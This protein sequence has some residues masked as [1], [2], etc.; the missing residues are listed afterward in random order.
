MAGVLS[1]AVALVLA[2]C[3]PLRVL[4]DEQLR[5]TTERVVSAINDAAGSPP[6]VVIVQSPGVGVM[7]VKHGCGIIHGDEILVGE[8]GC[9]GSLND[10]AAIVLVHEIG[11]ALGRGHSP[12][13]LSVMFRKFRYMP[14][15]EAAASL[16]LEFGR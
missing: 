9:G 13:P 4:P 16:V 3:G 7:H 14:L 1:I 15:R 12:D 2:A 5:E 11:H 8:C 10:S 6:L